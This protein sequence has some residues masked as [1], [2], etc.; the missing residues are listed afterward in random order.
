MGDGQTG[1][2]GSGR[3]LL[4]V[5]SVLFCP[6]E[7]Q[8]EGPSLPGGNEC[9]QHLSRCLPITMELEIADD[10]IQLRAARMGLD[11]G[12][13]GVAGGGRSVSWQLS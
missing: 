7:N 4:L 11:F 13:F 5:G 3:C 1:R 2:E 9:V 10:G 8:Q 6:A 12:V